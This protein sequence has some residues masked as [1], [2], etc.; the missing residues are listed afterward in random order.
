MYHRTQIFGDPQAVIHDVHHNTKLQA[1]QHAA[2]THRDRLCHNLQCSVQHVRTY[3]HTRMQSVAPR[4][5][6]IV[7]LVTFVLV[8]QR[9]EASLMYTTP[10]TVC[11]IKHR[12]HRPRSAH[13]EDVCV[14]ANIIIQSPRVAA[15]PQSSP[16]APP[17]DCGC[18]SEARCSAGD[19]IM[20]LRC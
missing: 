13:I 11:S 20:S 14:G 1:G 8:T 6:S 19:G 12:T 7:S 5:C 9:H 17:R 18:A 10:M 2:H 4:T 3:R 15:D 16:H